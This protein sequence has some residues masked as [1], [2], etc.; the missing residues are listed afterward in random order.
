MYHVYGCYRAGGGTRSARCILQGTP[1][2]ARPPHYTVWTENRVGTLPRFNHERITIDP[3]VIRGLIE[4][5]RVIILTE[6]FAEVVTAPNLQHNQ[7]LHREYAGRDAKAATW[8]DCH[9]Q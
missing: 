1:R 5:D 4:S 7:E 2:A 8:P 6:G 9:R 3:A